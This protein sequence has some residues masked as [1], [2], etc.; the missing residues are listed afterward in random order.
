VYIPGETRVTDP[1]RLHELMRQHSFGVLVTVRDGCPRASHLP[2]LVLA[3]GEHGRLV[4]HMARANDQWQDFRPGAEVL[5][6]FQGEHAYVSPSWYD[7]HPSVP[8]WNY[9]VV[10][11]RGV[12][13][14]IEEPA[15]VRA[16]LQ[17]LVDHHERG[18]ETPWRMELP[19]DYLA[20]MMR[21]IV[22]FEI[23]ISRIEG[24]FKLSQNRSRADQHRVANALAQ[25]EDAG[26][27]GAADLMIALLGLDAPDDRPATD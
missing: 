14:L 3:G 9:V 15:A 26:A 5:V 25:S 4:A 6:V 13:M 21:A 20:R 11:A 24:K 16:Y 1:R 8:T 23:P 18:F 2:F 19:A 22:A 7:K 12:P 10:H 17:A 27:R